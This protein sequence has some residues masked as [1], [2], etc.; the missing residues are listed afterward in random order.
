VGSLAIREATAD[1]ARAIAAVHV[2]SWEESYAG[3]LERRF[4]EERPLE[5]RFAQ[6][7]RTL[8]DPQRHTF[9]AVD[10]AGDVVGFAT[11]TTFDPPLDGYDSYLGALYLLERAKGRGAGRALLRAQ[12]E[13]LCTLGCRT[14]ALRVLREN[15]ARR[16]YERLGARLTVQE[17]SADAGTFDDVV[18]VF[19]DVRNLL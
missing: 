2:A 6:W 13:R 11:A 15:P 7:E 17:I 12:A 18:Y 3:I 1:D 14:L 10:D 16:F 5:K 19:D 8:G 9:V 4:F